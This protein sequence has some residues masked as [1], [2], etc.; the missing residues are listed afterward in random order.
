MDSINKAELDKEK[1]EE[2]KVDAEMRE[3]VIGEMQDLK[4]HSKT[5]IGFLKFIAENYMSYQMK[6]ITFS[7]RDLKIDKIK[8]TITRACVYYHPDK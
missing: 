7:D 6:D 1:A 5:A 8:R 3:K 4:T 2:D